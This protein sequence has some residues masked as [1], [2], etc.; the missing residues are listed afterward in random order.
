M[1]S[2]LLPLVLIAVQTCQAQTP[3]TIE[4]LRREFTRG[5]RD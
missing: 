5:R 3:E 4:R 1:R 2:L